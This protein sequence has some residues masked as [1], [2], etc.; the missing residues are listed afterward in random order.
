[1]VRK[2][3]DV[4]KNSTKNVELALHHFVDAILHGDQKHRSWLLEA[5][6]CFINGEPIPYPR[7]SGVEDAPQ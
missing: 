7:G 3:L 6:W 4:Y 1:M 2:G 5:K